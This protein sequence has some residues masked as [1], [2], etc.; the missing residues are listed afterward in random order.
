[1][2]LSWKDY[3]PGK[4]WPKNRGLFRGYEDFY[5]HLPFHGNDHLLLFCPPIVPFQS[6]SRYHPKF[7]RAFMTTLFVTGKT[8]Q[9]VKT[10]KPP[11]ALPVL[12]QMQ[13]SIYPRPMTLLLFYFDIQAYNTAYIMYALAA[14]S[15]ASLRFRRTTK[16]EDGL[17]LM[18][19]Q[20]VFGLIMGMKHWASFDEGIGT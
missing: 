18:R 14:A 15:P 13:Y 6:L 10:I 9:D 8:W 5:R 4:H 7:D 11:E 19:D 16:Q 12:S 3:Y 1:M 20:H 2:I 17:L